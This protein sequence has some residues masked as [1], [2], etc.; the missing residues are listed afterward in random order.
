MCGM[1]TFGL[2][3]DYGINE[4][5]RKFLNDSCL[6]ILPEHLYR[7]TCLLFQVRQLQ[8]SAQHNL[9]LIYNYITA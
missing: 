7:L 5:V 2:N 8:K 3:M 9:N 4:N 1:M 6:S